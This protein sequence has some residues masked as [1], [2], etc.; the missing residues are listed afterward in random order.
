MTNKQ[1]NSFIK[2]VAEENLVQAQTILKEQLNQKLTQIL[3]EKFENYAP[4]LFEKLDA[5]GKEDED[6]DN[7]GD[8][9]NTDSYLKN[10]REVIGKAISGEEDEA[11]G[12]EQSEE[13]EEGES[14]DE[15]AEEADEES[16]EDE[17]EEEG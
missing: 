17:E 13:E 14:E 4:T 6:I 8:S 16:E 10:R 1:I 12:E 2:M 7:D 15:D 3:N 5:V 11:E 9:D